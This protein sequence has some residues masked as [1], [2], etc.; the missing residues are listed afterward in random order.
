MPSV[1]CVSAKNCAA[2]KLERSAISATVSVRPRLFTDD[3]GRQA[4]ASG[5]VIN[6]A[7]D[8]ALFSQ[9]LVRDDASTRRHY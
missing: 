8:M 3:R 9:I 7:V 4:A 2:S 1:M 6:V 5:V